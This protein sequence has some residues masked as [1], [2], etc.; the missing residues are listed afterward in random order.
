MP[1]TITSESASWIARFRYGRRERCS[2]AIDGML[3]DLPRE[4]LPGWLSD[5]RLGVGREDDLGAGLGPFVAVDADQASIRAEYR[6]WP[7]HARGAEDAAVGSRS[8]LLGV[9]VNAWEVAYR[10]LD[11]ERPTFTGET[12]VRDRE[13]TDRRASQARQVRATAERRTD[14]G[15]EH[16]NVGPT[17]TGHDE[18][19]RRR[20][21]P[22]HLERVDPDRTGRRLEGLPRSSGL[23]ELAPGDLDRGVGRWRLHRLAHERGARCLDLHPSDRDGLGAQDGSLRIQRVSLLPQA[24]GALVRLREIAEVAQQPRRTPD[25]QNQQPRR[26]RVQRAGVAD[27]ADAEVPALDVD[28][29]V[30]GHPRGLVHEQQPVGGGGGPEH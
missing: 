28:D 13:R 12:C 4:R 17:R 24:A 21:E 26:H 25:A 19:E 2:L 22:R 10:G 8:R 20:R 7:G 23:V 9:Q 5:R 15:H 3:A 18:I 11:R 1:N 6:V 27:L 16:P 29:I 14:I 30:R